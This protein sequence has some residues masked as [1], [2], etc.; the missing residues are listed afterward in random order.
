MKTSR[1][2]L[3]DFKLQKSNQENSTDVSKLMGKMLANCHDTFIK[4]WTGTI[5]KDGYRD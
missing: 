4:D 2:S 1:L 3:E 5:A